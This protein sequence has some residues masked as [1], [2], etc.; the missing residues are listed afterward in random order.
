MQLVDC[1][2][3]LSPLKPRHHRNLT[4]PLMMPAS[5]LLPMQ[6]T[7]ISKPSCLEPLPTIPQPI[8]S[9][10]RQ[11]AEAQ[12]TGQRVVGEAVA[13]GLAHDESRLWSPNFTEV[14]HV[15]ILMRFWWA[16]FNHL[17]RWIES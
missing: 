12:K 17:L 13:S 6:T 11:I 2:S 8:C 10:A 4:L 16:P 3:V 1:S 7:M 9:I 5:T 14:R 15:S